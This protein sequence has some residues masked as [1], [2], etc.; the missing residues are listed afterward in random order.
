MR[1]LAM[2]GKLLTSELAMTITEMLVVMAIFSLFIL[3]FYITL[4]V[5]MESWKMGAV[6]SDLQCT[7]NII[8]SRLKSELT[9]SNALTVKTYSPVDPNGDPYLCFST[10]FYNGELQKDSLDHLLWQGYILYYTLSDPNDTDFHRKILYRR[11]IPYNGVYPYQSTNTT[12]ALILP[13]VSIYAV[14]SELTST[15][16]NEGQTLKKVAERISQ[17]SFND[18]YGTVDTNLTLKENFR[19]S[20]NYKVIFNSTGDNGTDRFNI[21]VSIRPRN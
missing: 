16:I 11:Y 19:R 8:I 2:T 15:E 3:G 5:G 1:S 6:K 21:A 9:N 10:A 13:N 4:N 17:I 12:L 18:L 14:D 7:G 20:K